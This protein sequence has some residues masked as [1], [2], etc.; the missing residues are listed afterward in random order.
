MFNDFRIIM[1]SLLFSGM[2]FS[3]Q[4]QNEA[5]PNIVLIMTD[6]QG[7]GDLSSHGNDSLQTPALDKL[8]SESVRF[9]R[10]YVSPVCAPTR[11]SLLTGRYHLRT[12]TTW[13]THRKEVMREDEVTIA[14]IL[15][16]AGYRTGLFGK[17]HNGE[18]Y[19]H[20]PRGQGFDTFF[21][22]SAGHWNNYFDTE[23][24]H[25]G[26]RVK[27]EGYISD[28]LT[29]QAI[30]FIEENRAR[31]FFC[32]IPYNAPHSPMQV[33]DKYFNR[34]KNNGISDYNAAVYGM[35]ENIDDN[36]SRILETLDKLN[37]QENTVVLFT[38]DNGPNGHRF[39]GGMKG[40][41]ADVDEGGVRVPLFI[42]YPGGG[43]Q[44]GKA[45]GA[46][47]A[48]IDILPTLLDICNLEIPANLDLDGQS[49]AGLL[50][51]D[52][53]ELGNRTLYTFPIGRQLT[54][55]PGAVRTDRYRM[56]LE[57]D[58]THS[59]YDMQNDPSQADNIADQFPAETRQLAAEYLLAF[60][61]VTSELGPPPAIQIGHQ[62]YPETILPAP[63]ARLS[64]N[65]KFS[66][67]WGWANDWIT[68][69]QSLTDSI[70]WDLKVV[71]AA[72]YE[73]IIQY[74]CPETQ[75]GAK[76][77]AQVD[78]QSL[79]KEITETHDPAYLPSPDRIQRW[80]VYEKIW[81]R[82]SLGNVNIKAGKQRLLLQAP[83]I[84]GT[85]AIDL[86]SVIIRQI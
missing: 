58:S 71:E 1:L 55:Y 45:V 37:L 26:K 25:N 46:L 33:A 21:G 39:N 20:D 49:L 5:P 38:T 84:P 15:Q 7:W 28:V 67:Y 82:I 64:G 14:E 63:E 53:T 35:V 16:D 65:V 86:K 11:A 75:V 66:E 9:Q 2:F 27:T 40:K 68:N 52:S 10:F 29:D 78:G 24:F 61:E 76:I 44:P 62:G 56:V 19:P 80:E 83:K 17:W 41:K 51:G 74:T 43:F 22:F 12:G 59:L 79:A 60:Q 36:I 4:D 47:A 69:W 32:Y 6:D 30:N 50:R 42:R 31:P 13:V 70:Y 72:E 23:L 85:Q 57:R 73:V 54:P 48:H 81:K 18:Q 77:S 34:L 3:C 8:R